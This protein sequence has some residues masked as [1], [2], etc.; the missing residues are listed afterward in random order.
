MKQAAS[1]A[2]PT[3]LIERPLEAPPPLRSR[4]ITPVITDNGA[5]YRSSDFARIVGNESW[6]Q[7]TRP[8]TPPHKGKVEHYQRILS[9]ELLYAQ[10]FTSEDERAARIGV[11]DRGFRRAGRPAS[12]R[13]PG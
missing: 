4:E 2:D 9:E 11:W 3:H 5:C 6:H 1:E 12:G 7:K 10:E 8:Y 13:S